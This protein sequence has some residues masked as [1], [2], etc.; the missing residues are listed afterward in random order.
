MCHM[1][2]RMHVV[3]HHSGGG[4]MVYPQLHYNVLANVSYPDLCLYFT[5]TIY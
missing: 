1:R 2:R 5:T 3:G 4:L